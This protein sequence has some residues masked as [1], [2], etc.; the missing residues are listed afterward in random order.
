MI[1]FLIAAPLF[2]LGSYF[3]KDQR[4]KTAFILLAAM[5]LVSWVLA[6]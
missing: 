5:S 3:V 4:T 6:R 1:V 2:L